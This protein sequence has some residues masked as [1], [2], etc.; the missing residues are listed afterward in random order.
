MEV[1]VKNTGTR[2]SMEAILTMVVL[3]VIGI[4]VFNFL[5]KRE[6]VPSGKAVVQKETIP[7]NAVLFS[8]DDGIIFAFHDGR[9]VIYPLEIIS[10]QARECLHILDFEEVSANVSVVG[11]ADES[12]GCLFLVATGNEEILA[13]V[14]EI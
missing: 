1:F 3:L 11:L 8:S 5:E 6:E 2:T 14:S 9:T 12:P 13:L 7:R 4:F 10:P